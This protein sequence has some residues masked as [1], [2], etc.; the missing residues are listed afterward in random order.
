MNWVVDL[1]SLSGLQQTTLQHC[2]DTIVGLEETINQLVA[3]VKKLEKMVCQCHDRLLLPG[4]HYMPGEE[5]EMVKET[6]EEE[7]EEDG[8]EYVTNTPS[9]DS[10]TTPPSTW[11][12]S[13][14]SPA[15]SCSPTLGDSDPENNMVLHTEELE[16]RIEAFLEEAEEDM[17][18]DNMSPLENGSSASGPGSSDSWFCSLFHEYWPMLCS[19][20]ESS[21]EGFPSLQRLHRTMSL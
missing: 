7:D 17:E 5:E 13:K 3:L 18:I 6:E 15:L 21:Q 9:R 4:P 16:A 14:P 8:L 2:Q 1:K 20:Q 19:A 10:Y 11:G 12:C